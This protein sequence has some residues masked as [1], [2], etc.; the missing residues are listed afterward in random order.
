[1]EEAI[2]WETKAYNDDGPCGTLRDVVR[3]WKAHT[4]RDHEALTGV[5]VDNPVFLSGWL[6]PLVELWPKHLDELSDYLSRFH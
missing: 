5:V 6:S 1:M 3:R 2:P 4:S